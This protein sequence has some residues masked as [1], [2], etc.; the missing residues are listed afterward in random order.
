MVKILHDIN[1]C[2]MC[3]SVPVGLCVMSLSCWCVNSVVSE[4]KGPG[5]CFYG[6]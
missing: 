5:E 6:T 2:M 3:T 4:L 1:K